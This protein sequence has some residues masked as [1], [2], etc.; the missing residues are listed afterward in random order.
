MH[1]R[2]FLYKHTEK[3]IFRL[4]LL[5]G[6]IICECFAL[7]TQMNT[8]A[9]TMTT[10]AATTGR[11]RLTLVKKYFKA[12]M[13]CSLLLSTFDSSPGIS[14]AGAMAPKLYKI[15]LSFLKKKIFFK[16]P[17]VMPLLA[18]YLHTH[19]VIIAI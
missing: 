16:S 3:K 12:F 10:T 11:T 6:V 2:F 18:F 17:N 1:H 13:N 8:M 7:K 19:Y 5:P 14:L 15:V 9:L 4:K